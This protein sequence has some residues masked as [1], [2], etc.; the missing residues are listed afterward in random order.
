MFRFDFL[1]N[2]MTQMYMK[3]IKKISYFWHILMQSSWKKVYG[4]QL[5]C[6][7]VSHGPRWQRCEHL[8]IPHSS[9]LSQ[10]SPQVGTSSVQGKENSES[11]QNV[12]IKQDTSFSTNVH[13][14]TECYN[15]WPHEVTSQ[16]LRTHAMWIWTEL[17]HN[18][19]QDCQHPKPPTPSSPALLLPNP[20]L[21]LF[22]FSRTS[23]SLIPIAHI[24]FKLAC[25]I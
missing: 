17:A 5:T 4:I 9:T 19:S 14:E 1:N 18:I 15:S 21:S 7:Q 25:L 22:P 3:V 13:Q 11:R 8:W 20:S 6:L 16:L 24:F 23:C 2:T 10:L 12:N